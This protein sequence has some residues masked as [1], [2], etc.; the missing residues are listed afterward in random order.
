MHIPRD[1]LSATSCFALIVAAFVGAA[2][3]RAP[4]WVRTHV[5]TLTVACSQLHAR[6]RSHDRTIARSQLPVRTFARSQL[7]E[8]MMCCCE[9]LK[10]D[11][12]R[13]A[14]FPPAAAS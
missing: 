9:L 13:F 11:P 7:P 12:K 10:L 2:R 3:A 4:V 8:V 6:S 1:E 5:C 14:L